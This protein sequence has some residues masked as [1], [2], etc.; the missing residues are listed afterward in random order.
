MTVRFDAV[1]IDVEVESTSGAVDAIED[2]GGMIGDLKEAGSGVA[3]VPK[4]KQ[5]QIR[6]Y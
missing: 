4:R 5:D 2:G 6:H 3:K 1:E